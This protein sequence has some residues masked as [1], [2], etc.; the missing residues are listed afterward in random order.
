MST[1]IYNGIKF[2]SNNI[3][4]VIHQLKELRNEA[5][6]IGV[7][8]LIQNGLQYFISINNLSDKSKYDILQKI[9][10]NL[11]KDERFFQI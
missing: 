10:K 2:K 6:S 8:G 4:E 11:K 3:H 7:D 9:E 1:K 5:I